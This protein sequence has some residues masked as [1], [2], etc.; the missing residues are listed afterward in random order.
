ML[1]KTSFSLNTLSAFLLCLFVLTNA[2]KKDDPDPCDLQTWFLDADSD[3]LGDPDTSIQECQQPDGYVAN[4]EDTDDSHNDNSTAIDETFNGRIDLNSLYNYA[5]QPIPNY[6]NKDNTNVN[7]ITDAGATLG[8]VLFYD[9]GLSA[10]YSTACA[11]CHQQAI[12]FSDP[13][14]LS[15]GANDQTGR[16]SMR[17][18]NARFSEEIRFFWDERA[19]SLEQQTTMP[20]QD[21]AEMGFSGLNGDPSLDDLIDRLEATDYYQEL[22]NYVYGTPEVTEVRIQSALAQFVRSIQSFD[23]KY[24]AGLAGTN[25]IL[26]PFPNFTQQENQG[27]QLFL[28]P[29]VFNPAGERV[30]G[31][32]GCQ[33]CHRGPEFDIDPASLNNGLIRVANNPD[34]TDL[35]VTRAPSLRDLFKPDGTENG[36]FMH[37]GSLATME[38]VLDHY[39]ELVF[40]P[41]VN[42]ALDVRLR[43]GGPNGPGQKLQMTDGEKE[44]VIAFLKTLAGSDVY[45]NEKWSDPF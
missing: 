18:I 34:L 19:A 33:G 45:T 31:G 29:P 9:R 13:E 23:S 35:T 42:N 28:A 30:D 1:S 2:C 36:P 32:L 7:P 3:G 27:K 37:D 26:Q 14:I 16:H 12:A 15:E 22:F 39:N 21:H 4:N 43:G 41:G 17:L 24:D 11:D 38:E 25:N 44:A 8:R 6:I 20:I 5:N 10:D 40:D